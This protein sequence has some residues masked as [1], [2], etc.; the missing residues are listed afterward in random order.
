MF[1]FRLAVGLTLTSGLLLLLVSAPALGKP[2]WIEGQMERSTVISCASLVAGAPIETAGVLAQSGFRADRKRLPRVGQTFYARVCVGGAGEPCVTQVARIEVVLPTGVRI[3]VTPRTPVR[4]LHFTSPESPAARLTPEQGCPRRAYR[5]RELGYG[6]HP[7]FM[8]PRTT[9]QDGLWELPRGFGY[10]IDFPLR[11]KR[12]LKGIA[13]GLPTCGR[14]EGEPPCP[15][16]KARDYLQ[17]A[18]FVSDGN[19]NP[20]VVPRIGLFVRK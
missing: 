4:C 8:F 15:P 17:A 3:A 12:A 7:S 2:R 20:W 6:R 18:I 5:P 9:R 10:F 13:R 1:R 16:G 14:I 11:S 19:S